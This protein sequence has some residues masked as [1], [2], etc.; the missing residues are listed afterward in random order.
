MKQHTEAEKQ[1]AP[2]TDGLQQQIDDLKRQEESRIQQLR[3]QA[4]QYQQQLQSITNA[5]INTRG[6]IDQL[7]D[8]LAEQMR[9]R[10]Q[11]EGMLRALS[12]MLPQ[13]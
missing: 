2:D 6:Q 11:L 1:A 5:T 13:Q 9:E 7:D 8:I 3:G 10:H 4:Q 12:R